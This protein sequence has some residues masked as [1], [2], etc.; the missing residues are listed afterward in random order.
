MLDN[1]E[2]L[3]DAVGDAVTHV[4]DAAPGVRVLATSQRALGVEGELTFPL[5]PLADDDAVALFTARAHRAA[6]TGPDVLPL[7]RALDGLPLAIELA[8]ARTRVLSVPEILR[9][10]DD[11]FALLADPTA[12]GP[13]RRRTLAAALAWSYDLLFPDDQRGLWALAAFP[14]GASLAAARA[15]ARRVGRARGRPR[16]TSS[17]GWWTARSSWSTRTR[18]APATGSSTACARSRGSGRATPP[19]SPTTALVDW[20]ARLAATVAAG[21]RG[22]EQAALVAVTAAERATIDTAL[23]C[24]LARRPGRGRAPQAC[25]DIAVGFGWA[26]VLLDDAGAAARLRPFADRADARLLLSFVEAMSGDLRAARA[27]LDGVPRRRP[28]PRPLVRWVRAVPGGP[29]RRGRRRSGALPHGVRARAGRTGGR[30]AACCWPRSPASASATWPTAADH[31]AAAV[32]ILEPLG[33]AWALQHAEAALGRIAQATGRFADAA[34]HHARAAAATERL[35]FPGATAMHLLH[36]AKA[37]LAA[38]DPAAAATLERATAGAEQAGD[39]RLLT[40]TRVTRAE[41]LLAAG[42]RDAARELLVAADRWYRRTG[43]ARAPTSPASCSAVLEPVW[44]SRACTVTPRPGDVTAA[45]A[46]P[47]PHGRPGH[48]CKH[49]DARAASADPPS[50]SCEGRTAEALARLALDAPRRGRPPPFDDLVVGDAEDVDP[51]Q[52]ERSA[53]RGSAEELAGAGAVRVEVLDD[54]VALGDVVVGVAAPV[55]HRGPDDLRGLAQALGALGGAGERRVV[56]DEVVGEVA[57]DR[58]EVALGEEL[59]DEALDE[60]LVAGE[61]DRWSCRKGSGAPR[62][63]TIPTS[64]GFRGRTAARDTGRVADIGEPSALCCASAAAA[65]TSPSCSGRCWRRCARR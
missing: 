34:R 27:A 58:R 8:A 42:H 12:R 36:L 40:Q 9:R 2:H 35:G 46:V 50:A 64:W 39:E 55:G 19:P 3:V 16:S 15:R 10:L 47:C 32:R 63:R 18:R 59:L 21:V 56:V 43:R 62:P 7:C 11:R 30:A 24:A 48:P 65:S 22:P 52:D 28:G 41:L 29:L 26:W 17:N 49:R 13:E 45:P 53:V 14:A 31:C 60:V 57:V 38:D 4:L 23:R 51:A 61:L 5:A 33:D 25:R 37:Q 54:E 20:V 44:R 6:G 1:C